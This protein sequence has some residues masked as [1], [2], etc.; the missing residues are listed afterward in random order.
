MEKQDK[1]YHA[2]PVID[3]SR[4][5]LLSQGA[6]AVIRFMKKCSCPAYSYLERRIWSMALS[7]NQSLHRLPCHCH[8][9]TSAA[10]LC[11]HHCFVLY[12]LFKRTSV[13]Y[14]K[15][16]KSDLKSPPSSQSKRAWGR[17][18]RDS[19]MK[20]ECRE[21]MTV[22]S[23]GN[24]QSSSSA[25]ARNTDMQVW[26]PNWLS[27]DSNRCSHSGLGSDKHRSKIWQTW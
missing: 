17:E 13:E 3:L 23:L 21:C 25:S 7:S 6:E 27:W 16:T 5:P 26:T 19:C 2:S 18:L 4:F 9:E 8:N 20:F 11:W 12:I 24:Q 10:Q 15:W 22:P 1:T 14:W